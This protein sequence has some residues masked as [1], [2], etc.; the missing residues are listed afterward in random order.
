MKMLCF[1]LVLFFSVT[2]SCLTLCYSMNWSMPGFPILHYIPEFAQTHVHWALTFSSPVATALPSRFADIL[3]ATPWWHHPL[4]GQSSFQF[5][6]W[7]ILN[8]ILTI[9]Q[10]HSSRMLVRSC[11]KSFMIGFSIMWSK[12]FQMAKLDLD[13]EEELEIKFP[14]FT[15]S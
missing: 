8:N 7:V 11:L 10:L 13:K 14:T 1:S 15:G 9:K 5:S 4:R 3:N 6:K 2:K 12:N